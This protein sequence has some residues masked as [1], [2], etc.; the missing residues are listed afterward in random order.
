MFKWIIYVF[1]CFLSH[2]CQALVEM[3]IQ[4]AEL[5][6]TQSVKCIK[7][8]ITAAKPLKKL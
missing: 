2:E 4:H 3:M 7:R 8:N 1:R 5:H 6:I